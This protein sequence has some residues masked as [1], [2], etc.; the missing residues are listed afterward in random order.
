MDYYKKKNLTL[1]RV[2][3]WDPD[4]S[5]QHPSVSKPSP[6]SPLNREHDSAQRNA[7]CSLTP[8]I[9][10]WPKPLNAACRLEV[11]KSLKNV[12]G[13]FVVCRKYQDRITSSFFFLVWGT[14]WLMWPPPLESLLRWQSR[15]S[16][17]KRCVLRLNCLGGGGNSGKLIWGTCDL[18][19]M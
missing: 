2:C 6:L 10:N 4:F 5:P 18:K 8:T 12:V 11:C 1:D 16:N 19:K 7:T 14:C 15:V 13:L 17:K 9:G 3:L